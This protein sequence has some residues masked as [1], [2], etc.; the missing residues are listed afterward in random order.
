MSQS[1]LEGKI[2]L[3]TGG[4]KGIGKGIA[5]AFARAGADVAVL[6]R[7]AADIDAVAAELRQGGRRAI[8]LATDVNDLASLPPAVD[9]V[10]SELGG[11]DVLVNCAGG[12]YHWHSFD[13]TTVEMLEEQ[14]RFTVASVYVL[15]KAA[16]PHL[17]E[18]PG[19]S[20]INIGSVTT[21]SA[22]R[23]H[24]AYETAKAG[25]VQ[26]TKSLAADLG[27][28]IRVNII[29]PGATETEAL[30]EVMKNMPPEVVDMIRTHARMRRIGTP[31]DIGSAAVFLAS[32]ASSY[33][34]GIELPVTGGAV[35]EG[36]T[37]FPDL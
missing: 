4:G 19:A 10:V 23:G 5:R 17:L 15:T 20:I 14:F 3:V 37:Q 29:H 1:S 33:V 2:A 9:R 24:L 28:K 7:T 6:S 32:D 11:L 16:V 18:R 35:D 30:I 31:E 13:D 27:P 34:T 8:S 21:G 22:S 36:Q 25:L 26:L 12:G